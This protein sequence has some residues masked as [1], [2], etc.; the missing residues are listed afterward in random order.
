MQ[1][2]LQPLLCVSVCEVSNACVHNAPTA[3]N[4]VVAKSGASTFYFVIARA[5]VCCTLE[6]GGGDG[7][8]GRMLSIIVYGC[9]CVC[10]HVGV[11][12]GGLRPLWLS[13]QA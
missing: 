7:G 1:P 8:D 13:S 12:Q 2:L 10:V 3:T 11:A 5:I 6:P 9:V 4:C